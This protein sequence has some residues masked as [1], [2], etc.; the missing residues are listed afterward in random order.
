MVLQSLSLDE[1]RLFQR[2]PQYRTVQVNLEVAV[3]REVC[4]SQS[5]C[6]IPPRLGTERGQAR[7]GQSRMVVVGVGWGG[8]DG[9]AFI[10]GRTL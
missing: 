6:M 3:L 2:D 10:T 4:E 7:G 8:G 9:E 1:A 5:G